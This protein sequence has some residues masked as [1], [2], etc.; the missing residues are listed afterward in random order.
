MKINYYLSF[1]EER[2]LSMDEYGDELIKFQ[3]KT[4]KT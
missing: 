1:K 2:R 3:K 4:L